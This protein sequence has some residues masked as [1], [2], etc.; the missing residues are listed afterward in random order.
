MTE[1]KE[2]LVAITAVKELKDVVAKHDQALKELQ[3]E[4]NQIS[5]RLQRLEDSTTPFGS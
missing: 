4:F 5:E 3:D 2:L 1:I